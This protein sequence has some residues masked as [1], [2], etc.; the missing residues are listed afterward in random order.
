VIRQGIF[1]TKYFHNFFLRPSPF[2]IGLPFALRSAGHACHQANKTVTPRRTINFVLILWTVSGMGIVRQYGRDFALKKDMVCVYLPG[3]EQDT[4]THRQDWEYRWF[5][6]DG[7]YAASLADG[8]GFSVPPFH[9]GPCP[10]KLF[11]D[12]ERRVMV[13][14][15]TAGKL[16][17]EKIFHLLVH[18]SLKRNSAKNPTNDE[19]KQI[20]SRV[21]KT[22]AEHYSDPRIGVKQVADLLGM[23]RSAMCR[24]LKQQTGLSPK[25]YINSLRLQKIMTLLKESRLS[26]GEIA[27]L[28]GFSDAH[29]MSKFFQ[30]KTHMSPSNFRQDKPA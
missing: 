12:L 5:T 26:L 21:K 18:I 22:I 10:E 27:S 2:I 19:G 24:L 6:M 1:V 28:A 23:H 14:D 16:A 30:G 11:R 25:E 15:K 20:T 29:Y 17:M 9:V 8:F 13:I 4:R 7:P 3:M